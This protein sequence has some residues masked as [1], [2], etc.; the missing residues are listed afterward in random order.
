[1]KKELLAA[2]AI[3]VVGGVAGRLVYTYWFDLVPPAGVVI[4]YFR[5][6]SAPAGTLVAESAQSSTRDKC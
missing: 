2:A 3:V 1:L 4:N 5:T 6:L